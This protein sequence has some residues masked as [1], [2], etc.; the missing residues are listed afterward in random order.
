M[1]SNKL[2]ILLLCNLL[3]FSGQTYAASPAKSDD[4]FNFDDDYQGEDVGKNKTN[5]VVYDPL[6]TVNRKIFAFNEFA[7]KKVVLPVVRQ[8]HKSVPQRVR[9]SIGNFVNNLSAPFSVANSL[10][11]GDGE[12][13]M[14]SF[15]AFLINSTI[16]V[17]GLFD[18]AGEKKI[19]YH[20]EDLG[21]SFGRYGSKPGPYLVI[22]VFGPSDARDLSGLVI[23]KLVS[24]LSFNRFDVGGDSGLINNEAAISLAAIEGISTREGLIEIIDDIRKNSFDPYSTIR[25]A[26]LQRRQASILNQ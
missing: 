18:V 5:Q 14:A 20:T 9:I 3:Y 26:Y 11:Q 8:Y 15:S 16:G 10:I 7:D 13:A 21:Q 24:P 6:E 25:S 23:E 17:A 22:P 19:K 4:Q 1:R 12:N 2:L